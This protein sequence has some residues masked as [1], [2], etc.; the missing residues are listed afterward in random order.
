MSR[1]VGAIRYTRKTKIYLEQLFSYIS[2]KTTHVELF[3]ISG[4]MPMH[5]PKLF[6]RHISINDTYS[7]VDAVHLFLKCFT[8]TLQT[9]EMIPTIPVTMVFMK[10]WKMKFF[11][12]FNTI[13]FLTLEQLNRCYPL[14]HTI[15]FEDTRLQLPFVDPSGTVHR[16]N[17]DDLY[18][19]LAYN[20]NKMRCVYLLY[21]E[22][23]KKFGKDVAKMI[24]NLVLYRNECPGNWTP[25]NTKN[26]VFL[27]KSGV[28]A[29]FF[30]RDK[31]LEAIESTTKRLKTSNDSFNMFDAVS[32]EHT[33][34]EYNTFAAMF[35]SKNF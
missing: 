22:F 20:K 14:L 18:R 15:K 26:E 9:L 6:V 33:L 30:Q 17:G 32:L 4:G 28:K 21:W 8:N 12:D 19:F 13:Y 23:K 1:R 24:C 27:S 16:G 2:N 5:V 25:P 10:L 7:N 11:V 35:H 34:H 29:A 31:L 3:S